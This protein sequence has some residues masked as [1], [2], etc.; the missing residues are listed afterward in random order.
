MALASERVIVKCIVGM[1]SLKAVMFKPSFFLRTKEPQLSTEKVNGKHELEP[2]PAKLGGLLP[3]PPAH[4]L[5]LA[6]SCMLQ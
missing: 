5:L 1:S 4:L 2:P 3:T 6:R